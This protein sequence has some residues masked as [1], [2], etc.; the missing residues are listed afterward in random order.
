LS[1]IPKNFKGEARIIKHQCFEFINCGGAH[2]EVADNL[3]LILG[4]LARL[5]GKEK[6][7]ALEE[8]F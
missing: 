3:G 5:G 4:S 7:A 8:M 1:S 2:L 6:I